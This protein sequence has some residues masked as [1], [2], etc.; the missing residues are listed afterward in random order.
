MEGIWVCYLFCCGFIGLLIRDDKILALLIARS[1]IRIVLDNGYVTRFAGTYDIAIRRRAFGILDLS[2]A[3]LN[4]QTR[5]TLQP[6]ID[7]PPEG[8]DCV[9]ELAHS[10]FNRIDLGAEIL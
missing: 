3:L 1:Y 10:R 2:R 7:V 8:N 9:F 6:G 4:C 5:L